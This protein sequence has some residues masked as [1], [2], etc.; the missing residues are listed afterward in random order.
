M[1]YKDFL[2]YGQGCEDGRVRLMNFTEP[3]HVLGG[4]GEGRVEVCIDNVYATVCDDHWDI[5]DARVVCHQLNN[6][7]NGESSACAF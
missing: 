3:V 6:T 5:L 2:L 1:C 7:S 4:I